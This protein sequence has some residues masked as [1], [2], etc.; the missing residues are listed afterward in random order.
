MFS[1]AGSDQAATKFVMNQDGSLEAPHAGEEARV[2]PT[3]PGVGAGLKLGG[4]LAAAACAEAPVA[5]WPRAKM[6]A[7]VTCLGELLAGGVG[8]DS[9]NVDPRHAPKALEGGPPHPASTVGKGGVLFKSTLYGLRSTP[10]KSKAAWVSLGHYP[11]FW[12]WA[13]SSRF[14]A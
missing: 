3:M 14:C 9:T 10:A 6:P 13:C 11:E 5:S 1:Q 4:D 12:A 2:L 8:G 7:D